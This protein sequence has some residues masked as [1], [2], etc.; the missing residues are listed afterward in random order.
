VTADGVTAAGAVLVGGHE[1]DGSAALAR[2]A[3]RL[4]HAVAVPPGRRLHDAVTAALLSTETVVVVP[5]TFGRD[6]TMV[7]DTA[8]T[9]RW[10]ASRHDGPPAVALAAPFGVVDH[11]TARLRAVAGGVRSADPGAALV[12]A[13]RSGG[14]FDDAELH[15]IAHLVRV[16]GAGVEVAVATL[17]HDADVAATLDRLRRLGFERS[18]VVPAGFAPGLGVDGGLP[19]FAGMSQAG[20]LMGDAAVARIVDERVDAAL[21]DLGH[22]RDGIAAGLTADHGHGYAHSHSHDDHSHEDP[23]HHDHH[24]HGVTR[25]FRES[26]RTSTVPTT[27]RSTPVAPR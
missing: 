24:D 10:I 3:H 14:P 12:V 8:R 5:M 23:D 6:P 7:A 20:P 17:D 9:L 16:H 21:H 25:W 4:P 1:S 11:L 2:F 18:V 26:Q 22:G 27:S 19:A 13:A 15:R